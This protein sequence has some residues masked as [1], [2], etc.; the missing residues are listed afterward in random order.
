MMFCGSD[1]AAEKTT[2]PSFTF[3]LCFC[4]ITVTVKTVREAWR[5]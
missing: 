2:P 3:L 5:D 1:T 4:D